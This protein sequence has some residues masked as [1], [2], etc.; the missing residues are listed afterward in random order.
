MV[1]CGNFNVM[2]KDCVTVQNICNPLPDTNSPLACHVSPRP[3]IVHKLHVCQI[4][5][6]SLF[7][8]PT[9]SALKMTV[10]RLWWS[11]ARRPSSRNAHMMMKRQ[12]ARSGDDCS[13]P[14][15]SPVAKQA[16][17]MAVAMRTADVL[18]GTA[19]CWTAMWSRICT[20]PRFHFECVNHMHLYWWAPFV[21]NSLDIWQQTSPAT[22]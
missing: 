20:S 21:V 12:M 2:S 7:T 17:P 8:A 18:R 1:E 5:C 15:V 6:T 14:R 4:S 11:S 19:C 16:S 9:T 10:S 22:P 3:I 13:A